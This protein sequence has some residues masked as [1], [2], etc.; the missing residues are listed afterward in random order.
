[1]EVVNMRRLLHTWNKF[2]DKMI[3]CLESITEVEE[4]RKELRELPQAGRV[5][6]HT[7]KSQELQVGYRT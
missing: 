6:E 5:F 7:Q 1:M 4:A 2:R 3:Q